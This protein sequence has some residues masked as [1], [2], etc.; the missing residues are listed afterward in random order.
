MMPPNTAI[1]SPSKNTARTSSPSH[2]QPS[3]HAT[4]PAAS[5]GPNARAL[6]NFFLRISART[7]FGMTTSS[8]STAPT[9][10]ASAITCHPRNAPLIMS[11]SA[12]PTPSA[13]R[14]MPASNTVLM[15]RPMSRPTPAPMMPF[16]NPSSVLPGGAPLGGGP[17]NGQCAMPSGRSAADF[18]CSGA[19]TGTAFGQ[20]HGKAVER[21]S[22]NS[23]PV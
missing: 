6:S 20:G 23:V 19:M 21:I 14:P 10:R 2:G 1:N 16:K 3:Q 18:H 12:S 17:Q 8:V 15:P 9:G 13:S 11:R 7:H 22:P 5:P 4:T